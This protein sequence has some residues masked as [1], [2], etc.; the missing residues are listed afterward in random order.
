M[1]EH[2]KEP[3]RIPDD[4]QLEIEGEYGDAVARVHADGGTH[5]FHDA[6]R[7]VACV[8]ACSG[9]DTEFLERTHAEGY[10]SG[11]RKHI[12]C[13]RQRDVLLDALNK[14]ASA[15]RAAVGFRDLQVVAR[16]AL[17][18]TRL[19]KKGGAA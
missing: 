1:S 2:T 5:D 12:E 16:Q 7:I 18:E 8:N 19:N 9:I 10:A 13:E 15:S 11:F 14:I 17:V 6:R 3:W 4:R